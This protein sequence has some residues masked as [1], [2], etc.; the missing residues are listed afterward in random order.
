MEKTERAVNQ[1]AVTAR[2]FAWILDWIV[3][4]IL[5]SLPAIIVFAIV[6]GKGTVFSN[7]YVFEAMGESSWYAILVGLACLLS[8]FV[9]YVIVPWKILPGQTLAKKWLHLKIIKIDGGQPQLKDYLLRQ[10]VF[11]FLIE[12]IA[13]GAGSY[14]LPIIT[15]IS[16]YYIDSYVMIVW[17][18]L[19]IT[20]I[21]F[22]L[23][24]KKHRALHDFAAK[25]IVIS[26]QEGKS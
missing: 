25:T 1:S 9:Y 2:A 21:M 12:G 7:L 20:T 6:D 11:L 15:T 19:T 10:F 13:T 23:V 4:S 5:I 14:I 26:S 16:R 18:I 8:G 3:G 17:T 22:V 24:N